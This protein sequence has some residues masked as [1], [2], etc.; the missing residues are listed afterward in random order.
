[1]RKW[2]IGSLAKKTHTWG[3]WV[4]AHFKG[5]DLGDKLKTETENH[6]GFRLGVDVLRKKKIIIIGERERDMWVKKL[7]EQCSYQIRALY[8]ISYILTKIS[9][10][11]LV[12]QYII[13]LVK[14]KTIL[15]VLFFFSRKK[16]ASSLVTKVKPRFKR[17]IKYISLP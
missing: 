2:N 12:F 7:T 11:V 15:V 9:E 13:I 4:E 16:W 14:E 3:V 17:K 1:M 5:W 10:I 6:T 8:Y